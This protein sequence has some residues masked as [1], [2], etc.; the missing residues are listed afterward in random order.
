MRVFPIAVG[1]ALAVSAAN[2][3]GPG[4]LPMPHHRQDSLEVELLVPA[5][6]RPGDP[7]PLRLRVRNGSG[8]ALD[9]YLRGR[10]TTFDVIVTSADGNVVWQ[11]LEGEML[12][13]I[14]H[15][16]TLEPGGQFEVE[17]VWDQRTRDGQRV[18]P[19]A[20]TA[21]G[22]LLAEGE[23]LASPAVEFRIGS[24]PH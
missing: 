12:P 14:V 16:R 4:A 21:R 6:I 15:L 5:S 7:V 18:A 24:P 1:T 2:A 19:G 10:S 13:A 3:S 9:L 8:R 22:L 20:Y 11:R 23:P 17:A